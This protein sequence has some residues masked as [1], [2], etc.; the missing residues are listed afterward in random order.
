MAK[1]KRRRPTRKAAEPPFQESLLCVAANVRRLR[2]SRGLT[3]EKLAERIECAPRHLQRVEA[4]TVNVSLKTLVALAHALGVE[5]MELLDAK[6]GGVGDE[7]RI[8]AN[9]GGTS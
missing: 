2:L 5:T 1:S 8:A 6:A 3:Q 9:R 4:G 7:L